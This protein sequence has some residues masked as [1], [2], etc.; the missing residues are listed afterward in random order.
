MSEDVKSVSL[1]LIRRFSYD[2]TQDTHR[3][4]SVLCDALMRT[5]CSRQED[6]SRLD[7][8]NQELLCN[9]EQS[10]LDCCCSEEVNRHL[11]KEFCGLIE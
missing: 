6:E 2:A 1:S 11:N 5:G 3:R 7:V 10:R 9:N 8:L 4:I